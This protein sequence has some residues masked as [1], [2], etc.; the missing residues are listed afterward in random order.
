MR[1]LL[2]FAMYI[3]QFWFH[4]CSQKRLNS[5]QIANAPHFVDSI[6][7]EIIFPPD[8]GTS[9]PASQSV[10]CAK[11]RTYFS[12]MFIDETTSDMVIVDQTVITW[13]WLTSAATASKVLG[14]SA[15]ATSMNERE[16][17]RASSNIIVTIYSHQHRES[18]AW[19]I[20]TTWTIYRTLIYPPLTH[21]KTY[22]WWARS[23]TQRSGWEVLIFRV[24]ALGTLQNTYT[25][26]H[27]TIT[28]AHRDWRYRCRNRE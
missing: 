25:L 7:Y 28:H 21:K 15:T 8:T 10:C 12:S 17:I 2:W 19:D 11:L 1:A 16:S 4:F 6:K 3:T 22:I 14:P 26:A 9:K 24:F 27:N 13:R 20:R 18:T 5:L 23:P